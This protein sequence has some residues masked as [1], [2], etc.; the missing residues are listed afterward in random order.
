MRMTNLPARQGGIVLIVSLIML[1]ALT[2]LAVSAIRLSTA[3][4]RNVANSQARSEAM[5][6]AQRSIDLSTLN[7]NVPFCAK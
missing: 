3:N 6:S 5:S 7:R 2:L 1:V 4:L